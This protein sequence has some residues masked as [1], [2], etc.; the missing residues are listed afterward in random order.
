MEG[1][2]SIINTMGEYF[3]QTIAWVGDVFEVISGNELA[4]YLV[5]IPVLFVVVKFAKYILGI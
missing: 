3:S 1:T 2:T 4:L 5:C